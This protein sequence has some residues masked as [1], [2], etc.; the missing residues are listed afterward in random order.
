[1]NSLFR[2]LTDSGKAAVAPAVL[3]ADFSILGKEISEVEKAGAD[4]LH[5]WELLNIPITDKIN[6]VIGGA[7]VFDMIFITGIIA[8]VLDG[9]IM[10]RQRKNDRIT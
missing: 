10:F 7:D 9:L 6:A 5:L 3:S 4:F 8:V 1:M 2:Q